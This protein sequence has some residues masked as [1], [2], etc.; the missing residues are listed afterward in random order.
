MVLEKNVKD[1]M[2]S[3]KKATME[4][5]GQTLSLVNEKKTTIGCIQ[6]SH[7]ERGMFRINHYGKT[8]K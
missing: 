8:E 5:L 7:H 2:D 1:T 4:E 3:K 6:W